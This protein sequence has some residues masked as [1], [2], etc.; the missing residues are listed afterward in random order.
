MRY[1]IGF[2]RKRILSLLLRMKNVITATRFSDCKNSMFF[3]LD[4]LSFQDIAEDEEFVMGEDE[5]L[6]KLMEAY[7]N[8]KKGK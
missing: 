7:R 8:L 3:T 2:D 6:D 4:L 5:N 1:R